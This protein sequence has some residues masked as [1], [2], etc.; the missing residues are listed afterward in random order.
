MLFLAEV[1]SRVHAHCSAYGATR[2]RM[3]ACAGLDDGENSNYGLVHLDDD[4]Y[5][6][7]T[8][9]FAQLLPRLGAL[10]RAARAN[11]E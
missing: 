10:H 7:L 3:C 11:R 8:D 2:V 4:S 5:E 9:T 1:H 6:V